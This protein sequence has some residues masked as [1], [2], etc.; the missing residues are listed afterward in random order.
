VKIYD[1]IKLPAHLEYLHKFIDFV[2]RCSREQGFDKNRVHEIEL[3]TEEALVNIFDYAYKEN[4]G[5]VEIFCK[6]DDNKRFIIEIVDTGTPFNVL[7]VASPDITADIS[8]RQLG[9]LGVFLMKEFMD[10]VQY[11][12]EGNKN[13][14]SLIIKRGQATL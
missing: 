13:I 1:R 3:A 10:A 11:R 5:E 2:A 14:L 8:D 9:G 7:S 6:L 12:H 4:N